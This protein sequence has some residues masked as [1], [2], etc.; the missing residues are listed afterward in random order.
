MPYG[1]NGEWRP[2]DPAQAAHMIVRIATGELAEQYA[3]HPDYAP[4]PPVRRKRTKVRRPSKEQ[5]AL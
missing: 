4:D 3:P 5:P 1:P 2:S